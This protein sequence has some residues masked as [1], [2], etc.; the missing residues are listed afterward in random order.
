LFAFACKQGEDGFVA[1]GSLLASDS[2]VDFVFPETA[3]G[4][5]FQ[6]SHGRIIFRVLKASNTACFD[7]ALGCSACKEVTGPTIVIL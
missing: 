7:L 1:P 6:V 2:G 4:M 5:M 3:D